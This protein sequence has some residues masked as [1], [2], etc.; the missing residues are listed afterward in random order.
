MTEFSKIKH[1]VVEVDGENFPFPHIWLE[2]PGAPNEADEQYIQDRQKEI[3]L[4]SM[5]NWVAELIANGCSMA[6]NVD[7]FF[8]G[9]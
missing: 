8:K 3:I 2:L 5:S 6:T 9:A 1:E 4:H 7:G